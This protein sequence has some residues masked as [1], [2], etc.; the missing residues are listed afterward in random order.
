MKKLFILLG[1]LALATGCSSRAKLEPGT[2]EGQAPGYNEDSMI[3]VKVTIG[4]EG[5][6]TAIETAHGDTEEIAGPCIE[7]LTK[8]V[9]EKD[10]VDV[11][12][13]AGATY[14]SQGFLD[15]VK[16]ATSKK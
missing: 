14:T 15:A 4:E 3:N 6:I 1:L 12:I 10:S 5:K 11:D 7:Q 8:D 13:V 2:Y 16:D 9:I